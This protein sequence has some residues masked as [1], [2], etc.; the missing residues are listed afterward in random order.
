MRFAGIA[1]SI[2][3]ITYADPAAPFW[4]RAIIN[5]IELLSGRTKLVRL[6]QSWRERWSVTGLPLWSSALY[7]LGVPMIVEGA[8]WP[9]RVAPQRAAGGHRQSSVR[10]DGRH[11][12]LRAGRAAAA[13]RSRCWR[14]AR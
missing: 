2:S 13:G 7:W 1:R 12:D 10:P 8:A 4:E 5:S 9:P 3:P 6:Y 11:R 14:T